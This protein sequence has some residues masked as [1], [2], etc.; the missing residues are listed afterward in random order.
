MADAQRDEVRDCVRA[1]IEAICKIADGLSAAEVDWIATTD[2]ARHI[3]SEA[4]NLQELA[5]SALLGS[6]VSADVH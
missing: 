2:L 5:W 6:V 4:R 1:T 3:E